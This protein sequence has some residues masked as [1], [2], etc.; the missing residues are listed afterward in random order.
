M[1]HWQAGRPKTREFAVCGGTAQRQKSAISQVR[2]VPVWWTR[3][4]SAVQFSIQRSLNRAS[5]S[6]C[7]NHHVPLNRN[8]IG[9]FQP[10]R[11]IRGEQI[12]DVSLYITPVPL[13]CLRPGLRVRTGRSVLTHHWT[14]HRTPS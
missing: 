3:A 5:V 4:S 13:L 2:A 7:A 9:K 10:I 6:V 14:V 1:K 8:K 12:D 11:A